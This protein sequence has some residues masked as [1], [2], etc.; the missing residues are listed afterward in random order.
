MNSQYKHGKDR[1]IG[2]NRQVAAEAR[3][4]YCDNCKRSTCVCW[5]PE[6]MA[7]TLSPT[8]KR[9]V[10]GESPKGMSQA[11]GWDQASVALVRRGILNG[12]N[13]GLTEFGERVKAF[14]K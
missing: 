13:D 9:I 1:T 2:F 3:S 5:N 14:L 7:K 11:G 8:M 4:A 10:K 12:R 6:G